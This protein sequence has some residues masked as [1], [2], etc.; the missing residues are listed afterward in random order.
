[1]GEEIRKKANLFDLKR[2]SLT[3]IAI[4]AKYKKI[5]RK[6]RS[7][8]GSSDGIAVLVNKAGCNVDKFWFC[9]CKQ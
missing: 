7:L 6:K 8:K 5:A 3:L 4:E 1:M 9:V 2:F